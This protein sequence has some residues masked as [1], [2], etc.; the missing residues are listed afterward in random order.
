MNQSFK[1]PDLGEGIHEGE[2][3]KVLAREG[4]RV[5]E[6]QPI[7]VVETDKAAVEIPSPFSGVVQQILVKPGDLVRVGDEMIVFGD[8]DRRPAAVQPPVAEGAQTAAPA[9]VPAPAV[10][11]SGPVPASPSTRRLAR[12]LGVDIALVTGSGP[13]G[14]VT[15]E[16]VRAFAAGDGAVQPAPV[17]QPETA[18]GAQTPTSTILRPSAVPVPP[19]PDFARWGPVERVPLRSVRRATAR[20]MALAWSQV[21]HVN[22]QDW[23]DLTALD[24]FRR[25]HK[26]AVEAQGGKLTVTVFVLKAVVAALKAYP[27]FNASLDADLEE[28]VYKRYYHLGVAA[29]TER[30]L[31]VPVVRDVDRKSIAELAVELTDLVKRTRDGRATLDELQG[32]T[33]TITNIGALG[34]TG[35]APIVNY[36]EVAILGLGKAQLLPTVVGTLDEYRIVPRLK[37]PLVLAFDHRVLDGAEAARFVNR[38]I[39]LLEEPEKLTL[40]I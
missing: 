15:A 31:V 24:A 39:E 40:N 6:D 8:G 30:G 9:P 32:S 25:K 11:R 10:A 23:A 33:F 3:I 36:P 28:I 17:P 22:H 27:Q 34:G 21:P 2:V 12:E 18:A 26:P 20:H 5:E 7:L 1:L 29:D 16:D 35:F 14:R 13:A 4:E 19:L 37:M 38:V